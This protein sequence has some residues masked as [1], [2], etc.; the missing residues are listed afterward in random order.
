[1]EFELFKIDWTAISSIVSL[2]M[3][4]TTFV[5]LWVNSCQLKEMK[6]QWKEEHRPH[7]QLSIVVKNETFLLSVSNVGNRLA[8]NVRLQ[9][10]EF[11]KE[12]LFAKQLRDSF[13]EIEN[14]P[15]IVPAHSS[16]YFY[17]MPI[18]GFGTITYNTSRETFTDCEF[19][20]WV[21]AHKE[22]KINISCTYESE[23]SVDIYHSCFSTVL[24]HCFGHTAVVIDN[25]VD[26]ILDLNKTLCHIE[27]IMKKRA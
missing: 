27:K 11:F 18:L 21:D 16:K 3:V 23:G 6:R 17:L 13:V 15:L 2:I 8:T 9:F 12:T 25:E 22:V 5:T 19:E 7:I 1:M 24:K 4:I 14:I 20:K 26:A 10:N